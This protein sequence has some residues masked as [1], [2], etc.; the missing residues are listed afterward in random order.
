MISTPRAELGVV[1]KGDEKVWAG[2]MK[3][4]QEQYWKALKCQL[5]A[6]GCWEGVGGSDKCSNSVY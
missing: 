4:Q 6:L 2:V 1:E 5:M 3:R